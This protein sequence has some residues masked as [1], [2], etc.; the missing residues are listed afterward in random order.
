VVEVNKQGVFLVDGLPFEPAY[1]PLTTE[2]LR[3]V[4]AIY[5]AE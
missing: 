1:K 4:L 2:E 5:F 3:E